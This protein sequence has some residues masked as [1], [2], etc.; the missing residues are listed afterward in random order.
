M[1]VSLQGRRVLL[2]QGVVAPARVVVEAGRIAAV[3]LEPAAPAPDG[4][5]DLG[6]LL[7]A[8]G[9]VDLH[10]DAFERQVMPRPGVLVDLAIGLEDTDRQLLANGIT[11]A[12]H[13][14]TWSWEPG[15][16]SVATG[17]ALLDTADRLRPR[18]GCDHR[19]QLRHEAF[20]LDGLEDAIGLVRERRVGLVGFNDHT[21][22]MVA[23]ADRPTGNLGNAVRAGIEVPA[24]NA[25]ARAAHARADEVDEG[26]ARLAAAALEVGTPLLSHDDRSPERRQRF[27][28]LGARIAEFPLNHAVAQAA[29]AAGDA[30]I[31]GAPNAL[32]G[33]SHL[34]W[35]SAGEALALGWCTAL[36]SDYHYPAMLH[37]PFR[38][39]A[40]GAL[41]LPAA[42][43]LVTS[44]PA[45][46]A[47]LN[48]RGSV[49]VG[50]RADLIV[51]DDADPSLPRVLMS[52]V[53]GRTVHRGA[54]HAALDGA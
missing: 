41:D 1:T 42:L 45:G 54:G 16:R 37:A 18:L 23:A 50:R 52:M 39:A 26:L 11:T 25:L 47:G 6:D 30:V 2:P 5:L 31:M 12:F 24:F 22:A 40:R 13:G 8:P 48:D 44:A 34:G 51:V 38:L 10:G 33:R 36:V 20:C 15:L 29:H 19:W 3:D 14:L 27:R 4:G 43:V 28:T 9:L 7:L 49:A 53:G 21:P 17:R 35:L 46:L 32:R